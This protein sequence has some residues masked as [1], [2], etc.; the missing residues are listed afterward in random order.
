MSLSTIRE[1]I[2]TILASV[3]GI[4]V[5]HDYH[6]LALDWHKILNLFQDENGRIN[7]CMFSRERME[8]R[9]VTGCEGPKERGHIFLFLC[10]MGLSDAEGTGILFDDLLTRIEEKFEEYDTLNGT[11]MTITPY[12]GTMSG[13]TGMQIDLIEERMFGSVLCHY[14]ELRLCALERHTV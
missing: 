7:V 13:K 14:A 10:I 12:W 9:L 1:Q 4:G 5:I 11:C 6:R 2:K 8:K 3:E